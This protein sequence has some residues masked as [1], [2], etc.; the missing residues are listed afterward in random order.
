MPYDINSLKNACS[1]TDS[2]SEKV[3]YST[4]ASTIKGEALSICWPS[5]VDELQKLMRVATRERI[6]LTIRGSGTSLVG[7]SSPPEFFGYRPVKDEQDK[8]S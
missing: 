7:G 4:D 8:G 2:N 3:A 6:P 5:N 1:A